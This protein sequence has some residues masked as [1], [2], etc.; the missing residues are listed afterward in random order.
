[1]TS[2]K[3][4]VMGYSEAN[5][6]RGASESNETVLCKSKPL[7]RAINTMEE[8]QYA[9]TKLLLVQQTGCA[10]QEFP[11][12]PMTVMG[13]QVTIANRPMSSRI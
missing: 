6:D 7:V 5:V 8:I 3:L 4:V 11:P 2:Q 1:L 13:E 10:V 12:P 9:L